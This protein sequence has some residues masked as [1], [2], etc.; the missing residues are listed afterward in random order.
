[1][2]LTQVGFRVGWNRKLTLLLNTDILLETLTFFFFFMKSLEQPGC[3]FYFQTD[4]HEN[5][6]ISHIYG[7]TETN[8]FFS[9]PP[10]L[11]PFRFFKMCFGVTSLL[12]WVIS[13]IRGRAQLCTYKSLVSCVGGGAVLLR[14]ACEEAL[15]TIQLQALDSLSYNGSFGAKR[16][17]KN[18]MY[19]NLLPSQKCVE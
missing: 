12:D 16:R 9:F 17:K 8:S 4:V 18:C 10:I 19:W 6:F 7:G 14:Y 11:T 15:E 3:V 5:V 2:R 13:D 1:M